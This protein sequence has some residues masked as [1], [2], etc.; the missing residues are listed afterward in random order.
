MVK[1]VYSDK[2]VK[3]KKEKKRKIFLIGIKHPPRSLDFSIKWFQCVAV[4]SQDKDRILWWSFFLPQPPGK[5]GDQEVHYFWLNSSISNQYIYHGIHKPG[6]RPQ[7]PGNP[8]ASWTPGNLITTSGPR[9]RKRVG[10]IC[11][12]LRLENQ[13]RLKTQADLTTNPFFKG[14]P[15]ID[16]SPELLIMSYIHTRAIT[17]NTHRRVA[18]R[19]SIHPFIY[20]FGIQEISIKCNHVAGNEDISISKIRQSPDTVKFPAHWGTEVLIKASHLQMYSL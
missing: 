3:K 7:E 15:E 14:I 16:F 1:H 10:I 20:S 12:W 2:D 5:P 8:R 18:E 13:R 9:G 19:M 17:S 4:W 6:Q 11:I